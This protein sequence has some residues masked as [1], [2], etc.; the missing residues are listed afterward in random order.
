MISL[1][2]VCARTGCLCFVPERGQT[3]KW[4]VARMRA[5]F[6]RWDELYRRFAK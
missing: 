1:W 6:D 5:I 2:T 4:C 3:C